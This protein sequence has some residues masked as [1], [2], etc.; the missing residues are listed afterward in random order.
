ME[1]IEFFVEGRLGDV[2]LCED[3]L[4]V[5]DNFIA[6]FDGVSDRNGSLWS[7]GRKGGRFAAEVLSLALHE[8]VPFNASAE[9]CIEIINGA[10]SR[11][12]EENM[13]DGF[14]ADHPGACAVIYSRDRQEIWRVGD[15]AFM[16]EGQAKY[17][18]MP[19]DQV[20]VDFR[21]AYIESLLIEGRSFEEIGS[22]EIDAA[23]EPL[24]P[25]L[26]RQHYFANLN[27]DSKYAYG[28]INGTLIPQRLIETFSV[29][30]EGDEVILA[31]DGYPKI[32]PTLE[33]T[34][35]FLNQ[36]NKND[37]LR[38]GD[39]PHLRMKK[40]SWKNVDDRAYIRFRV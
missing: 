24:M 7:S 3:K 35:Y 40:P 31:S 37:P 27:S 39:Y 26:S 8:Q 16:I 20:M 11:A 38:I 34:E 14:N 22:A 30:K 1:V 9:Q 15:C 5:N 6:V 13:P 32:L 28:V 2:T 10:L 25:L 4:C 29:N 36:V 21:R 17:G 19:I 18:Y 23:W 12:I 33:D